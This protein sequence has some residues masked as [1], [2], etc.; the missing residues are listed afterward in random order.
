MRPL[1]VLSID[2]GGI[3]GLVPA[4]VLARLEAL[5]GQPVRRLF[6]LIAG[7]STGG[8]LALALTR[9]DAL[10][11][12]ALA[13]LY[14]T[15]GPTV[16][17]AP[18]GRWL[19]TAGGLLGPTYAVE[20]LEAL[21]AAFLGEVRLAD[22][23]TH[24]LVPAYDI[25]RHRPVLF[26]SWGS[27][28]GRLAMREV[29]RATSAAPTYFPPASLETEGMALHLIDGGVFANNPAL[30][31][32]AE[33]GRLAPGRAVLM[34]SLGTGETPLRR[35]G[36]DAGGWGKVGWM[37]PLLDAM[38]DG[39]S[40]SIDHQAQQFLGGNHLRL[41][42]RLHSPDLA[43]DSAGPEALAAL[44][45]I[46]AALLRQEE[47]RLRRFAERLVQPD[48][49]PRTPDCATRPCDSGTAPRPAG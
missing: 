9:P 28:A 32:L 2:G 42:P 44:E 45:R 18:P 48:E 21:L 3:R 39:M 11:A 20:G 30:C 19:G 38:F 46:A 15:H 17:A 6:D 27:E 37:R 47:R 12:R 14:R 31:A 43:M 34:L 23:E 25:T 49:T 16:F 33:A 8:I 1:R 10:P 40:D 5:T 13:T 4:R 41:Q 35:M 22:A 24:V 36:A 29:A 7:T 26:R